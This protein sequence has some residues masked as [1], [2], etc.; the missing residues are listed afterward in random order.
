MRVRHLLAVAFATTLALGGAY[1][2]QP[3]AEERRR[4]HIVATAYCQKGMTRS[5]TPVHR[6]VIAADP[7]VLPLGSIVRV[8]VP[9]ATRATGIYTVG[10]TGESVKGHR[11]DIY[12]PSCVHAK[13]FGRRV[14]IVAEL[15][16]SGPLPAVATK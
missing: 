12:M 14:A 15:E 10:D 4:L 6:G 5:G 1:R 3:Q 11:I 9:L 7:E 8:E 16:R 2:A 13:R